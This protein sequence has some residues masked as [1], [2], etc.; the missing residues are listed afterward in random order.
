M[1]PV[2]ADYGYFSVIQE[3]S[4][5]DLTQLYTFSVMHSCASSAATKY[6]TDYRKPVFIFKPSSANID[7][8]KDL[9]M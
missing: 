3:N 5:T 8:I 1:I 7:E 9:V 2:N 6:L 4:S